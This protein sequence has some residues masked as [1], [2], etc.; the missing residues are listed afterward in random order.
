MRKRKRE[1]RKEKSEQRKEKGDK[2]RPERCTARHGSKKKNVQEMLQE[3]VK[4][5]R[6][7]NKSD[8]EHPKK[9]KKKKNEKVEKRKRRKKKKSDDLV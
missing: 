3:I 7:K 6:Q 1:R 9:E 5:L 4:Q 8:F 2:K